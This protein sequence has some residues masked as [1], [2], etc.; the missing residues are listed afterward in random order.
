MTIFSTRWTRS[1]AISLALA[2]LAAGCAHQQQQ[3]LYV[4]MRMDMASNNWAGARAKLEGG[5]DHYYREQ[6]AVMYWLDLGTLIHYA[7]GFDESQANFVKAEERMDDLWTKSVT[8]TAKNYLVREGDGPYAGE[9]HEHVLVYLYTA[10]NNVKLGKFQ[11]AV[12]EARRAD[13]FLQK[14]QLQYGKDKEEG[15]GTLYGQDAFML[16]LVGLLYEMEGPTSVN[17]AFIAYKASYQAYKSNYAKNFDQPIPSYLGEDLVRTAKQ[18]GFKDEV[19]RFTK[20]TGAT[21]ATRDR[22][23]KGMGEVVLIDAHGEAPFKQQF[24][25][26]GV[27]PGGAR[28]Q[29]ALPRFAAIQHQIAYAEFSEGNAS[30]K[31]E[32]AEPIERIV[33]KNFE[34]QL[35]AI[36]RRAIVRFVA[37]LALRKKLCEESPLKC[38]VAGALANASEQTDLRTWKTLPADIGVGRLW[39]PAGTHKIHVTFRTASGAETGR[40][41]DIDVTDLKAGEHRLVTVRSIQ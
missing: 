4:Q 9:D 20:E 37:K 6:D 35:P 13:A 8:D 30:A 22:I 5:K 28:Q 18:L 29:I 27:L 16:W 38:R 31:T 2:V 25:V 21:G 10:L 24:L 34:F 23:A 3:E 7:N 11:D 14:L 1:G 39:L 36:K 17:D 15:S 26:E 40:F 32:L 33:L 19:A 41:E 12:V